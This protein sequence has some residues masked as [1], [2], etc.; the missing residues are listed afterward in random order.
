MALKYFTVNILSIDFA[1]LNYFENYKYVIS[2]KRQAEVL[3][4]DG[5]GFW[6]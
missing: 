4:F 5:V 2:Q 3:P 1:S 6:M